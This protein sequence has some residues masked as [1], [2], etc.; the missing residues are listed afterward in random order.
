MGRAPYLR[1]KK[2]MEPDLSVYYCALSKVFAYRCAAGRRLLE[3]FGGPAAVFAARRK[4]LL[5]V[6]P[7][8]A[9]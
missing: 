3:H 5:S 6:L 1:G 7:G 9:T 2:K 8:A 4:D